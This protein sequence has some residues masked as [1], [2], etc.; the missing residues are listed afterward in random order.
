M[1]KEE[2][3]NLEAI[4]E[5]YR[6]G[7]RMD[8]LLVDREVE[9]IA[10]ITDRP[11]RAVE[12]GCGNGY[13]TERLLK[14]F[15]GLKVVEPSRGNV[16]LMKK[17]IGREIDCQS[18]LLEELDAQQKFDQVVFLNV[19]EHVEDPVASLRSSRLSM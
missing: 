12:I 14:M 17:R 11:G 16:E 6:N 7:D 8:E 10:K 2:I 1:S 13:S 19:I 4:S 5:F 15:P 18:C 9:L 3:A